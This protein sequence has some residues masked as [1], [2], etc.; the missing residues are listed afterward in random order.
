MLD[1]MRKAVYMQVRLRGKN[2]KLMSGVYL[3]L[4]AAFVL[5]PAESIRAGEEMIWAYDTLT[6]EVPSDCEYDIRTWTPITLGRKSYGMAEREV[7]LED[8]LPLFPSLT[9]SGVP[10]AH[11][12]YEAL[13]HR[14]FDEARA[15]SRALGLPRFVSWSLHLNRLQIDPE[16]R[17]LISSRFQGIV[18]VGTPPMREDFFWG[19]Q[20]GY[21]RNINTRF[22]DVFKSLF[23]CVVMFQRG[24]K[25]L[26]EP[27]CPSIGGGPNETKDSQV[28]AY[29]STVVASRNDCKAWAQGILKRRVSKRGDPH[30]SA[31]VQMN[32]RWLW[33][34]KYEITPN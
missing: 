34:T 18:D 19:D 12:T 13:A 4:G 7:T 25:M 14:C 5:G 29:C 15:Y 22:G 9:M 3:V 30:V 26:G 8:G 2:M 11:P 21:V 28:A 33:G 10:G 20:R 16:D 6:S 1:V 24:K 27:D 31:L 23:A 32:D 17:Q